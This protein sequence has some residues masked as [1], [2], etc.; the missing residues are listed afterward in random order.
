[1]T[2]RAYDR[3]RAGLEDAIAHSRGEARHARLHVRRPGGPDVGT[4]R[5]KLRLTQEEFAALCGVS[6]ATIRNW[7]QGRRRPAGPSRALLMLVDLEPEAALR[8][9]RRRAA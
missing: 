2:K 3:I 7:E 1:M 6:V 4:I 9:I 5:G 8:S